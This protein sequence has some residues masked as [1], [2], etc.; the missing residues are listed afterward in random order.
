MK[1]G[2]AWIAA[3]SAAALLVPVSGI[4]AETKK[5]AIPSSNAFGRSF[6]EW[7]RDYWTW[8]WGGVGQAMQPGNVL[9]LTVPTPTEM[10]VWNGKNIGIG[11]LSVV[12]KPG[13]KIVLGVLAW[14]G[15]TYQDHNGIIG[16]HSPDDQAVWGVEHFTPPHGEAVIK[17]DG[18]PLINADN[19]A[20]FYFGPIDFQQTLWYSEASSY[21]STGAI[22]VQGIGVTVG[23]LPAGQHTLTLYSW[24]DWGAPPDS[25]GQGWFNTWHIT[26]QPGK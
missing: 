20:Q 6:A 9:F 26:V 22:W 21:G 15:E 13:T 23:P 2:T 17:L 18:V 8:S 7:Q 12:V 19:L 5:A 4:N 10:Q 11:E 3:L 25:P 14:I 16:S 24:D 1:S